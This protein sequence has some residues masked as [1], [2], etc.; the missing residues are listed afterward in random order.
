MLNYLIRWLRY[1][2]FIVE[3]RYKVQNM[4]ELYQQIDIKNNLYQ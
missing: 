3:N 4:Y 2:K 1:K